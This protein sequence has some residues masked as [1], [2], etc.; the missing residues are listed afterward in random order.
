[1][2]SLAVQTFLSLS[3][4]QAALVVIQALCFLISLLLVATA[5]LASEQAFLAAAFTAGVAVVAAGLHF[6]VSKASFA[7]PL[8]LA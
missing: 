3:S 7:R 1:V 6:S 5:C 2:I 8:D 4:L